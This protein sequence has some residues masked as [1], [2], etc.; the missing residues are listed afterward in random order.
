[1][2]PKWSEIDP[3][4]DPKNHQRR[5]RI[6]PKPEKGRKRRNAETVQWCKG[7]GRQEGKE[8]VEKNQPSV[9]K[10]RSFIE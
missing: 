7:K 9:T 6:D 2:T 4:I 8:R 10:K 1:M 5:P 3:K